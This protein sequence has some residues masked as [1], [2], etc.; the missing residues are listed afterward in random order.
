MLVALQA[1]S[2]ANGD[3]ETFT[4][5]ISVVDNQSDDTFDGIPDIVLNGR[6][7]D[8]EWQCHRDPTWECSGEFN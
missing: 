7:G 2:D 6:T 1:L 4:V 8:D 5:T 3:E